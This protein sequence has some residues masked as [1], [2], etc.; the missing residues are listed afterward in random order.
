MRLGEIEVA[1]RISNDRPQNTMTYGFS[2]R[3]IKGQLT[4]GERLKSA[5]ESLNLSLLDAENGS[6]VRAKFLSGLEKGDWRELPSPVYVRGFVLAYAKFLNLNKEETMRAFDAEIALK[7]T[8]IP[9]EFSYK[10]TIKET[11]VLITPKLL[12]Y[13]LLSVFI[14]TMFSYIFY[15]VLDFAGSPNLKVSAPGNNA[16]METDIAE[17]AGITDNDTTLTIN[18]ENVAVT[19]GGHFYASIKLHRGINVI[20]VNASNKAKKESTEVLTIEYKPKTAQA[21]EAVVNQ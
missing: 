1:R 5:R 13:S 2:T 7:R 11:K 15:Q 9:S 3:K 18:N 21:E 14:L 17:I 16:I 8:Q 4:L 6:K 10:N 12:G 19:N 20:K